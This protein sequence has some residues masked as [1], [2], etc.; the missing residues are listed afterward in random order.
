MI[1]PADRQSYQS[2]GPVGSTAQQSAAAV[3]L[4]GPLR[5]SLQGEEKVIRRT[6]LIPIRRTTATVIWDGLLMD[7][8]DRVLAEQ[9]AAQLAAIVE[10]SSDAIIGK[11]LDGTITSWNAAAEM[12]Y[13]YTAQEMIGQSITRLLP[14][15]RPNEVDHL[16]QRIA[17]GE[18]VPTFQTVRHAKDGTSLDIALTC[19]AH[20][21]PRRKHYRRLHHRARH[22]AKQRG[23]S[24]DRAANAAHPGVAQH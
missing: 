11:T 15:D 14:P 1:Q 13:G 23:R 2:G 12:M 18:S 17:R 9:Q 6:L 22:Q 24:T 4:A 19:F 5:C 16:L 20:Q 21:G 3:A 10:G 8:T 7:I